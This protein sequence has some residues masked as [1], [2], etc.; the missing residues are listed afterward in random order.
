MRIL[1]YVLA[2]L[3]GV[4]LCTP[5][6]IFFFF[7]AFVLFVEREWGHYE[8]NSF[9]QVAKVVEHTPFYLALL[10][11]WTV[12]KGEVWDYTCLKSPGRGM[13]LHTPVG[14]EWHLPSPV[15]VF[16]Q[17]SWQW[18]GVGV[19]EG[20]KMRKFYIFHL[21]RSKKKK[22]IDNFIFLVLG[23]EYSGIHKHGLGT[24][25]NFF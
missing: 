9:A 7:W 23:V 15:E 25:Q 5:G 13:W 8:E 17:R 11:S 2:L 1:V 10:C 19:L 18:N 16:L 4:S 14:A 20:G 22:K 6:L 21:Q 24:F 12:T 3:V